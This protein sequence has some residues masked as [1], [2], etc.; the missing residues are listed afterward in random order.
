VRSLVRVPLE[1]GGAILFEAASESAG[2]VK[3]GRTGEAVRDLP[4]T[5]Q[6]ALAPV[7]ETARAVLDQLRQAGP[8]EVEVEF[9]VDLSAEAGVV[10]T[11]SQAAFH[12]KVRVLWNNGDAS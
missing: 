8:G 1:G 10:I 4:G 6:Q 12:L 11:K 2:P 5:V 3:A 7:R 9:G